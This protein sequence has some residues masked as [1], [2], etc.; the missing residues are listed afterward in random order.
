YQII[1]GGAASTVGIYTVQVTLNAALDTAAYLTGVSNGSLATAQPL[2]GSFVNLTPSASASRG[3][4]MGSNP[5]GTATTFSLTDFEATPPESGY[6]INNTIDGSGSSAGLWH[7]TTRRST[8]PGHSATHSF[9]YGSESTGTYSTG[10][11]NAG[12]ITTPVIAV[13]ANG[14][15]LLSFNY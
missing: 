2:D 7:I 3:A 5:I 10:A 13:P 1:V 4:V 11:T 6:V 12:S 8:D 14:P 9:Y 15:I